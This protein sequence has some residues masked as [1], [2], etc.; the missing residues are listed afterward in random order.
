MDDDW[1]LPIVRSL[2]ATYR[3]T[4]LRNAPHRSG[5]NAFVKF[6]LI[7]P[8]QRILRAIGVT[9]LSPAKVMHV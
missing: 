1:T 9:P 5:A 6:L 7:S 2:A 4:V 3:V 8:E